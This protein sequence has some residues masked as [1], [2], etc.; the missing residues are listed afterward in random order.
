IKRISEATAVTERSAAF[1]HRFVGAVVRHFTW[2]NY[3]TKTNPAAP[4][5]R[6]ATANRNR[7]G[8][9]LPKLRRRTAHRERSSRLDARQS[10]GAKLT[11]RAIDTAHASRKRSP[12]R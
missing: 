7:T 11:W 1:H 3:P 8:R 5:Q 12:A 2:G 4:R 6:C 9:R 10:Y